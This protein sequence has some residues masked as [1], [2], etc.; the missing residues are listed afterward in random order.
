[1]AQNLEKKQEND[2]GDKDLA[3]IVKGPEQAW[4]TNFPKTIKVSEVI[5]AYVEHFKLAPSPKYELK[6]ETDPNTLL[7]PE[8]PLVSYG[9]KDGDVL[10]FVDFGDAV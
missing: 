7:K 4:H 9:V 10:V 5:T 2:K 8:R 3:V 6:L 1:M